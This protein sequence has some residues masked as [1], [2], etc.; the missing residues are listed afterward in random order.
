[1]RDVIVIGAGGG[2]PVVAKELAARGLDVLAA[3]GRAAPRRARAGLDALRERRQQPVRRLLPVSGPRDR[4]QAGLVRASCRRTRSSGRWP[5]VGGTTLHYYGNS[6]RAMPGVFQGYDGRGPRRLRPRAPVPVLATAS[7]SRTT[8]GSRT[9]LPV[10]TAAMG[11]KEELFFRGAQ[12]I[13]LPLQTTKDATRDVATARRRTRSSSRGGTAGHDR[14]TPRELVYPQGHRL[15]VLRL[16][17]PGL[18]PAAPSAPRNLKAKRSTDNSYVPM[19]LTADAWASGGKRGDAA[20]RRLRHAIITEPRRRRRR[21]PG[22]TWRDT[23][24][25]R[26]AHARTRGSSC[27]AGGCVENPRLWLNCGLPNPNGW[28]GRGFTDHFFDWVIGVMPTTR[29]RARAP[30]S[31]A[32]VDFPGAAGSRTSACRRRSRPSRTTFSDAGIHGLL[33][34]R[35]RADRQRGRHALGRLVGDRAARS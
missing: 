4:S 2:G 9:T 15:H 28:V 16:L 7:S 17:L 31:S 34:Q 35:P 19:A 26:D 3:R 11:T 33:R 25:R 20:H 10:Q 14:A 23:A 30:G 22:V 13:G 24:H 5:G 29:A 32:R 6:P 18:L 1:M 21:R 27:M 12:R 8:S